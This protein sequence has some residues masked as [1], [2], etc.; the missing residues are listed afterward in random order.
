MASTGLSRRRVAGGGTNSRSGSPTPGGGDDD[1]RRPSRTTPSRSQSESG[2]P[3]QGSH[4][5]AGSAFAGGHKI[6]YDPR[7]LDLS[8]GEESK[9]GGKL[10]KL[11]IMEEV[12][13]L[14]LKDK[15]VGL[16]RFLF[17]GNVK[18]RCPLHGFITGE[19]LSRA[20]GCEV[21]P[22]NGRHLSYLLW[23]PL[24]GKL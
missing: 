5:H 10:P 12:L 23:C 4:T 1:D 6:A 24:Y 3:S 20:V 16:F 21:R 11:T 14:G 17:L 18:A 19:D 7:D 2:G 22:K 13:L 8:A 9:V 15:Q